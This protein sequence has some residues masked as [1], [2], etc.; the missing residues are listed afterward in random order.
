M[1]DEQDWK[2][3]CESSDDRL[4]DMKELA[5][6]LCE[7]LEWALPYVERIRDAEKIRTA[8][9]KYRSGR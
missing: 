9:Q 5:N 3:S 7:A 1:S 6:E 8:I 2:Y 4:E